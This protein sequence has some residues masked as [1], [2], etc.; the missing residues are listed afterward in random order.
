MKPVT[1]D[2]HNPLRAPI[3]SL[4]SIRQGGANADAEADS[5][6]DSLQSVL[7]RYF[8]DNIQHIVFIDISL[9]DLRGAGKTFTFCIGPDKSTVDGYIDALEEMLDKNSSVGTHAVFRNGLPIFRDQEAHEELPSTQ[10]DLDEA[11]SKQKAG[12]WDLC[13]DGRLEKRFDK[14]E[15]TASQAPPDSFTFAHRLKFFPQNPK[16]EKFYQPLSRSSVMS[17]W[18][19]YAEALKNQKDKLR[20]ASGGT[21]HY[22]YATPVGIRTSDRQ[23]QATYTLLAMVYFGVDVNF[24][25]DQ[26]NLAELLQHFVLRLSAL[27]LGEIRGRWA[28]ESK[29]R[30]RLP[31]SLAAVA[32]DLKKDGREPPA[33]LLLLHLHTFLSSENSPPPTL[34]WLEPA[35]PVDQYYIGQQEVD[36]L[37]SRVGRLLAK[38]DID[39]KRSSVNQIL[40]A[41]AQAL[42]RRVQLFGELPELEF[43]STASLSFGNDILSYRAVAI[44]IILLL[45]EAAQHSV[46]STA[47]KISE[48]YAQPLPKISV[49]ITADEL[50][51]ANYVNPEPGADNF[52]RLESGNLKWEVERILRYTLDRWT[53]LFPN[54]STYSS[55]D[56]WVVLVTNSPVD[57]HR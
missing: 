34:P 17:A 23:G 12:V 9:F 4:D 35:Q 30:H 6:R 18:E 24:A 45:A 57:A 2:H 13:G 26:Y 15:E 28:E 22:L 52:S 48:G 39:R 19:I 8:P 51:I 11:Y 3:A 5:L 54:R 56:E 47:K 38:H 41:E 42:L 14:E 36:K 33:S 49:T 29:R 21:L 46:F 43:H 50:R 25:E 7:T 16:A 1:F 37:Y 10:L 53:C 44:T 27:Q 31:G 40:T 20:S 32:E 55:G